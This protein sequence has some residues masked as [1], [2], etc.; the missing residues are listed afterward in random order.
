MV[1]MNIEKLDEICEISNQD[2][3]GNL[4][5]FSSIYLNMRSKYFNIYMYINITAYKRI[6]RNYNISRNPHI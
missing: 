4:T 5:Y 2:L 1:I 3:K 6:L